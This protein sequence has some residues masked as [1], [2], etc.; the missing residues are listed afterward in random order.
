MDRCGEA[1]SVATHSV[2]GSGEA[3]NMR[4]PERRKN[5]LQEALSTCN[6]ERNG[7]SY[8]D[9][10]CLIPM[11]MTSRAMRIRIGPIVWVA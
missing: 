7:Q 1:A 4:S 10:R 2:G 5:G 11:T 8:R 6:P 9:L 3:L